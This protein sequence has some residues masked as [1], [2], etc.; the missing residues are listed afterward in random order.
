MEDGTEEGK[1][2]RRERGRRGERGEW[3][4]RKK[5]KRDH[6]IGRKSA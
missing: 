5:V 2:T 3:R 4:N 1:M 6:S